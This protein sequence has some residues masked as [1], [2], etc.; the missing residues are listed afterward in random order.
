MERHG[1]EA[2]V[3]IY[4]VVVDACTKLGD[5]ARAEK[6]MEKM[7][8]SNIE[9]NVVSHSAMIDAC[10]MVAGRSATQCAWFQRCHQ[11]LHEGRRHLGSNALA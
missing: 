3:T 8:A 11:R 5:A 9:P 10:A 4:T 6:W 1:L 7:L 2:R